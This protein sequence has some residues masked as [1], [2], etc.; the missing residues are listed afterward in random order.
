MSSYN[1]GDVR[2]L[3]R[4]A[5]GHTNTNVPKAVFNDPVQTN[6]ISNGEMSNRFVEDG[7]YIRLK[8]L[9]L[10]YTF[11]T[12]WLK[13][14]KLTGAR[15]Y[16]SAQNLLMFTHYSGYDP[17]S[18]NQSVKNSQLGIDWAVQPQPKVFMA[19]LSVNF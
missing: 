3:G 6:S 18:Q 13:K 19:G 1:N 10:G 16:V 14:A 7:S 15:L 9:T 17:E 8:N 5:N 2:T 12:D 11:R 4:W